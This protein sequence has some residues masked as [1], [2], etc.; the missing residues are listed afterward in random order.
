MISR[1]NIGLCILF[2]I[3]TCGIYSLYWLYCLADDLNKVDPETNQTSPGMVLLF[4]IITCGI[5]TLYWFYRAGEKI[6]RLHMRNNDPSGDLHILYLVLG[7]FGLGIVSY[8]LIQSEFNK[9]ADRDILGN[10]Q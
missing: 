5:Y 7:I 1:K 10:V 4:S 3:I 6:N 9:I 2:S 8:A